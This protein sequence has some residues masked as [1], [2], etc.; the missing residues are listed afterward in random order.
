MVLFNNIPSAIWVNCGVRGDTFQTSS[1]SPTPRLYRSNVDE[2]S[3]WSDKTAEEFVGFCIGR[4]HCCGHWIMN[5]TRTREKK[6][7]KNSCGLRRPNRI[8]RVESFQLRMNQMKLYE[9]WRNGVASNSP[10]DLGDRFPRNTLLMLLLICFVSR[11]TNVLVFGGWKSIHWIELR[12]L[13]SRPF[14]I[15]RHA[16]LVLYVWCACAN[17]CWMGRCGSH[18]NNS[19]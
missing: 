2:L 6:V 8:A 7:N 9:R 5:E 10:S 16:L 18:A 19:E 11:T 3:T 17:T 4:R 13:S 14:P 15:D 1:L 12:W